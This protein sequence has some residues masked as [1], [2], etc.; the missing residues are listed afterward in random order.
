MTYDPNAVPVVP[1]V[2]QPQ[3][4]HYPHPVPPPGVVYRPPGV[5]PKRGL[6][7]W[8]WVLISLAVLVMV[9]GVIVVGLALASIGRTTG[10]SATASPQ[11]PAASDVTISGCSQSD[12]G[13]ARAT[14]RVTNSTNRERDYIISISYRD[15]SGTRIGTGT[16]LIMDVAPGESAQEDDVAFASSGQVHECVVTEVTRY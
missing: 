1:G 10:P 13:T 9:G 3:A 15:A 8:A 12:F 2:P 14:I 4:Q 16:V 6:P 7:A 11:A 5:P